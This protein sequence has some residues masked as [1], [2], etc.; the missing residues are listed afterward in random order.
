MKTRKI[1]SVYGSALLAGLALVLFPAAGNL[2]VDSG[3]HSLSGAQY[4]TIFI[5]Q[6]VFAVISALGASRIARKWSMKKVFMMGLLSL[7]VATALFGSTHSYMDGS[8]DY[9]IILL[10]TAFLGVGFGFTITALNP[11]AFAMFSN[12]ETTAVTAMHIMLGLGT[13]GASLVLDFFA[14]RDLWWA[15]PASVSALTLGMFLFTIPLSFDLPKSKKETS[16]TIDKIPRRIIWFAIAVF[17]YGACEG[18]FGNFG[19]VLLEESGG[20]SA[21]KAAIGLSLFWAGV[22]L[23]R[24]AFS[25]ASLKYSTRIVYMVV[26]FSVAAIFYLTPMAD[27]GWLLLGG[28]FLGGLSLSILFPNSVSVATDEFPERAGLISGAMV[29]ALQLG[30]GLTSNVLGFLKES[31]D[32]SVLFQFSGLYALL[33]GILITWLMYSKE[34]A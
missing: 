14:K 28:M 30:T 22:T 1:V 33:L 10:A 24:V 15:A 18:T 19:A 17:L 26:P 11:F 31:Y 23:G 12:K 6:I 27:A 25:I 13:A 20:L 16:D 32:L 21:T 8:I 7:V 9:Y 3:H 34:P 29:A 2:L 5:P 4:G